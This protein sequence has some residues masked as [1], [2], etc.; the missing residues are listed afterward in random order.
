M[1]GEQ[2]EIKNFVTY[3]NEIAVIEPKFRVQS[4]Y[5]MDR[6]EK[7]EAHQLREGGQRRDS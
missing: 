4:T 1:D 5:W 3:N 2:E 6:E 7:R